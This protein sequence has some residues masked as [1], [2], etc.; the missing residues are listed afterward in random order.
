M[1]LRKGEYYYDM[2]QESLGRSLAARAEGQA[3]LRSYD[4]CRRQGYAEGSAAFSMCI[5]QKQE[6]V[7]DPSRQSRMPR[8]RNWPIRRTIRMPTRAIT[9]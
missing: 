9:M 5:L 2:C 1:G 4:D 8:R 3:R 7:A 6:L